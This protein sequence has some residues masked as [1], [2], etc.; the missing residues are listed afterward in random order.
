MGPFIYKRSIISIR[1]GYHMSFKEFSSAH[2]IPAKDKPNETSKDAPAGG[3]PSP[4]SS[5]GIIPKS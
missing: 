3:Q 2:T 1:K 5:G 4:E